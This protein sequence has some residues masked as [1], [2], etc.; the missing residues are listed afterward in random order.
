[1]VST[2]KK[3]DLL[4]YYIWYGIQEIGLFISYLFGGECK[5]M[6]IDETTKLI[7]TRASIGTYVKR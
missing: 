4:L 1:M 7:C 6:E 5:V 3:K 2:Q